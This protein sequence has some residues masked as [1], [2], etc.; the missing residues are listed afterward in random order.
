M[1]AMYA[2]TK[3]RTEAIRA[4][5]KAAGIKADVLRL[6]WSWR[7]VLPTYTAEADAALRDYAVLEGLKLVGG[8][9]ATD[10]AAWR[11]AWS[12]FQGRGQIF[13]YDIR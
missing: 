6:N 2:P 10:P 4:G 1:C 11:R 9:S 12:L 7:I 5:L 8:R 13:L 3:A